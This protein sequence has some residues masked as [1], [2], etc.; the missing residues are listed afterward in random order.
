MA[1]V[2]KNKIA[3]FC[4]LT[5]LLYNYLYVNKYLKLFYLEK[6]IGAG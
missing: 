6:S 5:C 4:Q 1:G 3:I 2:Y